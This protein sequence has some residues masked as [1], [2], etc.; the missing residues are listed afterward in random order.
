VDFQPSGSCIVFARA[1]PAGANK[2]TAS[3]SVPAAAMLAM[4][5]LLAWMRLG[6]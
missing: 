4:T 1:T 6:Q 2:A 3:K 5:A